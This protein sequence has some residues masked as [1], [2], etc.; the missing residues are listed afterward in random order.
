MTRAM[1]LCAGLGTRLGTLGEARPKPLLPV[2]DIPIVR[3]SI[4]L[5]VGHGHAN[6]G[7]LW[8][9][10]FLPLL[11]SPFLAIA[12][13][14]VLYSLFH[15]VRR[16]LGVTRQTC[17]C[18]GDAAPQPVRLM[19]D[20]SALIAAPLGGAPSFTIASPLRSGCSISSAN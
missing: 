13:A 10:F 8:D 12:A 14:A 6:L 11:V 2:A 20:G 4:A 9:S 18:V 3:Y 19:Q 15:R 7:K 5:L 16:K 1:L 17:I